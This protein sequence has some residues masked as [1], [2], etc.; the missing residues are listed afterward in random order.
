VSAVAD[1]ESISDLNG[2]CT[3]IVSPVP[4]SREDRSIVHDEDLELA[5][6]KRSM[7]TVSRPERMIARLESLMP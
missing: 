1:R 5:A 4:S 2:V 7:A 3:M 6:R